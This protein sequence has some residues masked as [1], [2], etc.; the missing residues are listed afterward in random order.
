MAW[1]RG[2]VRRVGK[3]AI[4]HAISPEYKAKLQCREDAV[5]ELVPGNPADEERGGHCFPSNT[6]SHPQSEVARQIHLPR[7][8]SAFP[9]M[10]H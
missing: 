1:R 9:E 3:A 8:E 7:K 2:N 6:L 4:V 5:K 10:I